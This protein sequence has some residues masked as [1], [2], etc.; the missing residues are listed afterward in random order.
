MA[1]KGGLGKGLGAIFTATSQESSLGAQDIN[2]L[3]I[4]KIEP[5][6][7]QPRTDIDEEA[8]AELSASVAQ[9]GVL[10]PIMVRPI[11]DKYQIIAGERRWRAA[12][13]AGLEKVPVV[14]RNSGDAETLEIALIENLQREDLNAIEAAYGYKRLIEKHSLTQSE[15]A[16]RVSKS[17]SAVTNTLRLIDLPEEVQA[18][19]YEGK[20]TAGHARAVLSLPGDDA[21]VKLANKIVENNLSVRDAENMARL[22][23]G[24]ALPKSAR[25]VAPK[26]YKTVARKLRRLLDAK[27]RVK[28]TKDKNK[29]EIEFEDEADL[30]RIFDTLSGINSTYSEE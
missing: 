11:G 27:V 19:L 10:M 21:R 28:Q 25:L 1:N 16:E 26:S 14:I 23:E 17:R 22:Y 4:N 6:P 3:P 29:I 13:L 12:R 30:M 20:L 2:E 7:D 18:L 8:I 15:L 5:N 9:H 24:G